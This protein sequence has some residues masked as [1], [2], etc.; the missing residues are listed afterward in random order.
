M[1][2]VHFFENNSVVLSQFRNQIP[3]VDENI[4]IKG[5]KVKVSSVKEIEENKFHV[6][7]IF[8]QVVKNK[9]I[10]NDTKKKKR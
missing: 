1:I 9:L 4:K 10:A 6:H 7:V 2:V 8:E 5:R 3:S